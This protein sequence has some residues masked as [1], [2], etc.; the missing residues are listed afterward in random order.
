MSPSP[1]LAP[2]TDK[3]SME[4]TGKSATNERMRAD[5]EYIPKDPNSSDISQLISLL[6]VKGKLFSVMAARLS[7]Y[8]TETSTGCA[9]IRECLAL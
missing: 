6:N 1:C 7:K 5:G 9:G 4:K 3:D 8:L 2:Q